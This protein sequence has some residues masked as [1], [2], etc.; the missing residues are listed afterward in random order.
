VL[1]NLATKHDRSSAQLE[2]TYA[3]NLAVF[4]IRKKSVTTK[5]NNHRP[6]PLGIARPVRL[7]G[8]NGVLYTGM[9]D[10]VLRGFTDVFLADAHE[11]Q[12][13]GVGSEWH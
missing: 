8:L 7:G 6:D 9:H 4:T 13:N 1:G 11:A 2:K 5:I 12:S 3:A 10:T